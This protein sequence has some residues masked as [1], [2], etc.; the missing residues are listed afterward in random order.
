MRYHRSLALL[1]L[2]LTAPV[3]AAQETVP[4][5]ESPPPVQTTTICHAT[6]NP[7]PPYVTLELGGDQLAVHQG[8]P[9][10]WIPAPPGGCPIAVQVEE[11]PEP[12]P[13]PE[14]EPEAQVTPQT[15]A[16]PPAGGSPSP[17]VRVAGRARQMPGSGLPYTGWDPAPLL[18]LG[19]AVLLAGLGVWYR[20]A[21]PDAVLA[22]W[23]NARLPRHLSSISS[24][25]PPAWR[26][27]QASAAVPQA[28]DELD[29]MRDV[30]A[31]IETLR[32]E[33]RD[34]DR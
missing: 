24:E 33:L 28:R 27:P 11:E 8:H 10:D 15:Q 16:T 14:S 1:V 23:H 26:P 12:E 22:A 7:D 34:P 5:G 13:E 17:A 6:F 32:T 3:A 29:E 2:A 4:S 19:F 9:A 21:G 31:R 25:R 20:W 18:L 30:V